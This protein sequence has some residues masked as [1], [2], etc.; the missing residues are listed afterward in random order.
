MSSGQANS[1][2]KS[3]GRRVIQGMAFRCVFALLILST[4]AL[5]GYLVNRNKSRLFRGY[6]Q[7]VSLSGRQRSLIARAGLFA[8]RIGQTSDVAER[9]KLKSEL[10]E[11]I[12]ELVDVHGVLLNGSDEL[13][14]APA[15]PAVRGIFMRPP[16]ELDRRVQSVVATLRKVVGQEGSETSDEERTIKTAVELVMDEQLL[17]AMEAVVKTYEVESG[18]SFARIR[19]VET[20]IALLTLV[21]IVV[22]GLGVFWPMVRQVRS[23]TDE[24]EN[25][26]AVLDQR[27]VELANTLQALELERDE[28]R[29][30]MQAMASVLEDL[31]EERGK[32]EREIQA[33]QLVQDALAASEQRFYAIIES[34]PTAM[35]M[36][37]NQGMIV[38]VNAE[39]ERLFGYEREEILGEQIE[40][41][42]PERFRQEHP[43]SRTG[44]FTSP[45]T[46][47]MGVGRVLSALRK[48]GTEVPV[49]I[50]LNPIET[51][52]GLFVL[53][54]I[55]DITE[56]KR[57]EE[58]LRQSEERVRSIVDSALDAVVTIDEV[59]NITGWNPQAEVV[60]GWSAEEALG[61]PMA[62]LIIP[63]NWRKA[64]K[65]G[66]ARF[67]QTGTGR[68]LNQRLELTAM[69]KP[70]VLF[71]I[72]ITIS[73]LRVGDRYEF[74]AFVR[75]I[76][77]RKRAE[78]EIK[79]IN[80][81]LQRKNN[82][83]QQF[84]YTVSHDL[85]SPLVTCRG[86]V[87]LMKEDAAEGRWDDVLDSVAR[88]ERATQRMG[89]LI[90]DLLQLSRIGVIRNDP[91]V[92]DVE[93][94]LGSIA[95]ELAERLQQANARLEIQTGMPTVYA[96][97][98]RLA[99]VFENLL[100]NAIKYGCRSGNGCITVGGKKADGEVLYFVKDNGPG[101]AKEFHQK[102]FGLF[103]RLESNQEGTG[104]GLAAVARIL[105]IHA[106]RVWVESEAG[107]GAT[108]WIAFPV[109]AT[110]DQGPV[111]SEPE[112][113][114]AV[115]VTHVTSVS[116]NTST[117]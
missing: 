86:F 71:P 98:V 106:G 75:D 65:A 6:Q 10:D 27:A 12:S 37:D 25:F 53:S 46:R 19:K 40:I 17:A 115:L 23:E 60:F 100:S 64:H 55:V 1:N 14:I 108:F 104:V 82:E 8:T 116:A 88:I 7:L 93:K 99:E 67:M 78:E 117:T 97:R 5:S 26:N 91:E 90:E 77:A 18:R 74:S 48:D 59:G 89:D 110:A 105:E 66:L 49:E 24:L 35:V 32:L 83:M 113:F 69:R 102:I 42:V 9:Q 73:P 2:R 16:H 44:F 47:R 95:E 109:P 85:K 38:L 101:I 50:G 112:Q 81:E 68:V 58:I 61:Q 31:E 33:R 84:V 45:E 107:H 4:I 72:E 36:T 56:R 43:E 54:A 13:K 34:A 41:L 51:E 103:Q 15:P 70:G 80:K 57:H 96:D 111:D 21:V 28:R 30:R 39:T 94:L 62:K 52:D 92:V 114:E 76:T 11:L 29:S 79:R 22:T 3:V 63:P 87:G 20:V